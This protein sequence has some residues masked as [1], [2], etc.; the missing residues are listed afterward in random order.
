MLEDRLAATQINLSGGEIL[1]CRIN[2]WW[3]GR[4][5]ISPPKREC[6]LL[7]S[8]ASDTCPMCYGRYDLTLNQ[9]IQLYQCRNFIAPEAAVIFKRAA[10][11]VVFNSVLFFTRPSLILTSDSSKASLTHTTGRQCNILLQHRNRRSKE[12]RMLQGFIHR[13]LITAS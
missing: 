13:G 7:K 3:V 5:L 4:A 11:L 9:S 12:Y 6:Y 8:I 1:P 10:D 2:L